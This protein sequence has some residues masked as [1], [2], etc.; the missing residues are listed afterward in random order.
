MIAYRAKAKKTIENNGL[1]VFKKQ[2]SININSWKWIDR[3]IEDG[4]GNKINATL[5]IVSFDNLKRGELIIFDNKVYKNIS[6]TKNIAGSETCFFQEI[7][8]EV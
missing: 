7:K 2:S 6:M 3:I 5:R 1:P 8:N 4:T